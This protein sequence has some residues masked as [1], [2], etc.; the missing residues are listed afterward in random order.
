MLCPACGHENTS[1]GRFCIR[2]G[3]P[4]T[5]VTSGS[6]PPS[7]PSGDEI[8]R[9]EEELER[10]AFA[11]QEIAAAQRRQAGSPFALDAVNEALAVRQREAERRIV[12][13]LAFLP[14]SASV[15]GLKEHLSH[16]PRDAFARIELGRQYQQ[17]G[18]YAAA[19]EQYWLAATIDPTLPEPHHRLAQ[20]WDLLEQKAQAYYE[21]QAYTRLAPGPARRQDVQARLQFLEAELLPLRNAA[22]RAALPQTSASMEYL[23]A[24]VTR[25]AQQSQREGSQRSA[26]QSLASG[27][28]SRL[29]A[30]RTPSSSPPFAA[31]TTVPAST[32]ALPSAA[33]PRI[34]AQ[35]APPPRQPT[36][37][38][39]QRQPFEWGAFWSALFS[40]RTLTALL[41]FGVLLITVSS[42]ALLVSLWQDYTWERVWPVV[43]AI[44]AG[45]CVMFLLS[46]YI[47]KE[48]L[49]L[50]LSGLAVITVAALWVPLN[51]GAWMFKLFG[52]QIGEARAATGGSFPVVPG[53]GVPLDLPLYAWLMV[54]AISAPVWGLLTYRFRGHLLAHGTVALLGASVALAIALLGILWQWPV[55]FGWEW[56]VA[57][58]AAM[59]IPL[60]V[61]WK[62]LHN[63][64]LGAIAEPMLWT[65]QG[66]LAGVV[67]TLATMFATGA[68]SGYALA[69]ALAS[70]S[71]LYLLAQRYA[72]LPAYA[73]GATFTSVAALLAVALEQGLW[74]QPYFDAALMAAGAVYVLASRLLIKAQSL[75]QARRWAGSPLLPTYLAGYAMTVAAVAWPAYEEASHAFV[76]YAAASLAALS[77]HWWARPH[78]TYVANGLLAGAVVATLAQIDPVALP[79]SFWSIALGVLGWVYLVEAVSLR[80][81]PEHAKPALVGAMAA[82]LVSLLWLLANPDSAAA[83]ATLP[84]TAGLYAGLAVLAHR[85]KDTALVGM[86]D[87]LVAAMEAPLGNLRPSAL[88]AMA[89]MALA[90][91]LAPIWTA[92]LVETLPLPA[93][94]HPYALLAWAFAF[95]LA[96][97]SLL[98]K[99]DRLYRVPLLTLGVLLGLASVVVAITLPTVNQTVTPIQM[100]PALYG[101]VALALLYRFLTHTQTPAYAAAAYLAYPLAVTADLFS[102]PP[103]WWGTPLMALALVYFTLGLVRQLQLPSADALALFRVAAILSFLA[104]AW[105]GVWVLS[106]WIDGIPDTAKM[107]ER[108][109][110][111]LAPLMAALGYA[112]TA[113]Q[114]RSSA[115][116]YGAV[117]ALAAAFAIVVDGL[118]LEIRATPLATLLG[119]A[120]YL[121]AAWILGRARKTKAEADVFFWPCAVAGYGLAA[122]SLAMATLDLVNNW[123]R[124]A[125][126]PALTYLGNVALLGASA[127]AFQRPAFAHAALALLVAPATL[128]AGSLAGQAPGGFTLPGSLLAYTWAAVAM[129]YL[130]AGLVAERK[131]PRYTTA[132]PLIAYALLTA[133]AVASLGD[134]GRQSIIFGAILLAATASAWFTVAK[135]TTLVP[136]FVARLGDIKV[137]DSQR[138]VAF[139]HIGVASL[140]FPLWGLETLAYAHPLFYRNLPV[141]GLALAL[142]SLP[143]VALARWLA[144]RTEPL[145][146]VPLFG[147]SAGMVLLSVAFAFPRY[148]LSVT[149][150][151]LA[152]LYCALCAYV[153]RRTVW[154]YLAL[155][156]LAS[157]A[158]ATVA[159]AFSALELTDEGY[160]LALAVLALVYL[161]G[162][163]A[164]ERWTGRGG[165]GIPAVSRLLTPSFG[166]YADAFARAT[167]P[168]YVVSLALSL[169]A[170]LLASPEFG[171]SPWPFSIA[172]LAVVALY[173]GAAALRWRI[174][175]LLYPAVAFASASYG[176]ALDF[177]EPERVGL[178]ILPGSAA[179]LLIGLLVYWR[180]AKGRKS[181]VTT[182][183]DYL[184]A[185]SGPL[186]WAAPLLTAGYLGALASVLLSLPEEGPRLASLLFSAG[187]S[188][189][190]L[191]LFRGR[192]WLYP[193]LA[194]SHGAYASVLALRGLGLE[195][196]QIGALFVPATIAMGAG[197]AMTLRKSKGSASLKAVLGPWPLP[198]AMAGTADAAVSLLLGAQS[199]LTGLLVTVTYALM[200]T[201][202]AHLTQVRLLSYVSTGLVTAAVIFTSRLLGLAWSQSAIVWSVQG[203]LMWCGGQA[204]RTAT[205]QREASRGPVDRLAIWEAPL[206]R[207]GV[208]LSWFAVAFVLGVVMLTL[209]DPTSL[210]GARLLLGAPLLTGAP[211]QNGTAVLAFLGL[212]YLGMAIV[213]RRPLFAY[214]ALGL[215]LASWST[216][217]LVFRV[218]H[219]QAYAIPTG[220]YLLTIAFFE[221]R[222]SPGNL[223]A[224]IEGSAVALLLLSAFWQS[225]VDQPSWAYALLLAA[226]SI[227]LVLW[228]AGSRSRLP[229]LGG[230]TA[231]V[232]DVLWQ[233]GGLLSGLPNAA[234]ALI[235]GILIVSAVAMIEWKRAQIIDAGKE[236]TRRLSRWQW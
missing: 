185:T 154:S 149:T 142:A 178:S 130:T 123:Q 87:N 43:Q 120:G 21:Y 52:P 158:T 44:L 160:G 37:P 217:L 77:A 139:A 134:A 221:R 220:L 71:G 132:A 127:Y 86:A 36:A 29:A 205:T 34:T 105:T 165:V 210:D 62:R 136:E 59:T 151:A 190:S 193:L 199:D 45:Q 202:A 163:T 27:Y 230:I 186:A 79:V 72:P 235:V 35:A 227:L 20:V 137:Q 201:L 169:E 17:Q 161:V 1:P 63:S 222:R 213:E 135:A 206:R 156:G 51:L 104:L 2:C 167:T 46:G 224:L 67:V 81:W 30:L 157:L 119:G 85:G 174:P 192:L 191:V 153:L 54:T 78:W 184:F 48:R 95:A 159:R 107:G 138:Y 121:G 82:S 195:T 91:A 39:V 58:L 166:R 144:R 180:L 208:R 183:R 68:G 145:L 111:S 32:I 38:P 117:G 90:A 89:F 124:D 171:D 118:P 16:H 172:A 225:V 106:N 5:R 226:E 31:A 33:T 236:W 110:V 26:L 147:A 231:F 181:T 211:L 12:Q 76:L 47:I 197:L 57:S 229:F 177:L 80:R 93:V 64:S 7:P 88:A 11:Q 176:L 200:T 196:Y 92:I 83:L 24:L 66:V 209:L 19:V 143:Y 75:E 4:L 53:I 84:V 23:I 214:L 187:A 15:D 234:I 100:L 204:V 56:P 179:S 233:T 219:F 69:F 108:L 173:Y 97:E 141:Q 116:G 109:V 73:Y 203:L 42:L 94:A 129:T 232:V 102:V 14:A 131:W 140:L 212:L 189:I 152:S 3:N 215:L 182:L 228:G 74:R 60:L 98:G 223:P 55:A 70:G 175:H 112:A 164:W 133:A 22:P 25:L 49:K 125:A 115:W 216:Q 103:L 13:A 40:E 101:A 114:R 148:G 155:G 99:V 198:F 162:T 96:G 6:N 50:H 18:G 207:A 122:G 146:A 8:L 170:A 65:S 150:L 28:V 218:S 194:S 9:L 168:F 41:G 61:A 113:Y 126:L 10:I 128:F 188:A